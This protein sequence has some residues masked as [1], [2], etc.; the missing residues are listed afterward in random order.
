MVIDFMDLEERMRLGIDSSRTF[1][2]C[3]RQVRHKLQVACEQSPDS[4]KTPNPLFSRL[5]AAFITGGSKGLQ[6]E[7]KFLFQKTVLEIKPPSGS[8][9][10]IADLSHPME[11]YPETRKIQRKIH[12]HVGP[13]NS[14]KTY[15][16]LKRLEE[17]ETGFYAGPLRLLAQEVYTRLNARGKLCA[18]ITGE[19]RKIPEGQVSVM[20]SCTVEMLPVNVR[21]DI[22]VIDEIQMLSDTERGWAWT[23]A[24]LGVQ[25]NEVHLCGELRTVKLIQD[26][27][28]ITGESLEIHNYER[29]T[30]LE[31]MKTSLKGDMTNLE[32][33]DC[34]IS[35]SRVNIHLTKKEVEAATGRKCAVVYGGLPPETRT[36][37]SALFNDPNNDYDFL[38]ASD[39]VGMGLNLSI[40]RIVFQ[41]TSKF[42]G[43]SL[44]T[45]GTSEIKQIAG[46][47]GRYRTA[48]QD[49]GATVKDK[50]LGETAKS[51]ITSTVGL[52]TTFEDADLPIMMRAMNKEANHLKAAA[53]MPLDED[54][55]RFASHYPPT[56]P[57]SYLLQRMAELSTTGRQFFF[58]NL[59]DKVEI[60][61]NIQNVDLTL[62]DR[63]TFI[64]SPASVREGADILRAFAKIVAEQGSGDL[65]DIPEL[66]LELLESPI[67]ANKKLLQ[68]LEALHKALTLYLWLSFR[69]STVFK[70]QNLAA[71]VSSLCEARIGACLDHAST[72]RKSRHKM[73]RLRRLKARQN[74]LLADEL[75]K[76]LPS[77]PA[78]VSRDWAAGSSSDHLQLSKDSENYVRESVVHNI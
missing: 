77:S 12:L 64:S 29:L 36:Q 3:C 63:L 66:D 65:L 42:D 41:E 34:I 44:R 19:E 39:A 58:S 55:I 26:L 76:S 51:S 47:A 56:T 62:R 25:A 8:L 13:T 49:S 35:F 71:H 59:R 38:A 57:L 10:K 31:A 40:K 72:D 33:G 23:N 48:A 30:P 43:E 50:G 2:G 32:K 21:V 17:A 28:K 60:A 15:H 73:Q 24:F 22:A 37:Q 4:T 1:N 61:D 7:L 70:S 27:C 14:G 78:E 20:S 5:R 45:M 52:V 46:R 53:I 9:E 54:V 69:F 18:L 75:E 74:D 6:R 67:S 16:A 68:Q 11:W